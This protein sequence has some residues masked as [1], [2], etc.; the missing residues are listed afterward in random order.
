MCDYVMILRVTQLTLLCMPVV[1]E[2]GLLAPAHLPNS[3]ED[4][5]S[6][7]FLMRL[8]TW[9]GPTPWPFPIPQSR[10]LWPSVNS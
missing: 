1:T 4:D 3:N 5:S 8:A 2:G 6:L 9:I 7:R 10:S